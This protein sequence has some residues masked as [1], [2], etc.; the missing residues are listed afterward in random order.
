[1]VRTA[2]AVHTVA[3]LRTAGSVPRGCAS[4]DAG[5]SGADRDQAVAEL[6]QHFQ[7]GR[8][9]ADELDDSEVRECN[10]ARL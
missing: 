5:V 1:M 4:G 2:S 8:L 10:D 6:S 9:T 7:A 3:Q